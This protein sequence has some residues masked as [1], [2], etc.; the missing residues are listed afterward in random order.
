ME[1]A[2]IQ[3]AVIESNIERKK[4]LKQ[5]EAN[6]R[7]IEKHRDKY[8]NTRKQIEKKKY[9][10]NEAFREEKKRKALERYYQKKELLKQ[11]QEI[12]SN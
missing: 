2:I 5:L 3:E 10:S 9:D 7:Y 1:G 12:L 6:K 4:N 11:N 8:N